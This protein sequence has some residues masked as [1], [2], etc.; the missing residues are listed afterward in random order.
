[1]TTSPNGVD[2]ARLS[3]IAELL[4]VEGCTSATVFFDEPEI[5]IHGCAPSFEVKQRLLEMV[6]AMANCPVRNSMRVYP[7]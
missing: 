7:E 1:M 6:R 4:R 2:A 3:E 5:V